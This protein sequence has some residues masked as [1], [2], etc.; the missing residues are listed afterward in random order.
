M[1]LVSLSY[2]DYLTHLGTKIYNN[3]FRIIFYKSI[4]IIEILFLI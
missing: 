3:M 1:K 2:N 4:H